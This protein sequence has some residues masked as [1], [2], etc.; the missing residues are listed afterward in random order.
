MHRFQLSLGS[1]FVCE[2][3][4]SLNYFWLL[5]VRVKRIANKNPMLLKLKLLV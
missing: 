4:I 1:L 2:Q 5:L 3:D